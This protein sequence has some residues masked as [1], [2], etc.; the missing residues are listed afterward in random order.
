MQFM[1]M[2]WD[3]LMNGTLQKFK[4][5]ETKQKEAT[6]S[7]KKKNVTFVLSFQSSI[8]KK[9][10]LL[11]LFYSSGFDYKNCNCFDLKRISAAWLSKAEI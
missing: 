10:N 1:K 4:G 9:V 6:N 5:E 11:K 7:A 3:L 2:Q 8:D